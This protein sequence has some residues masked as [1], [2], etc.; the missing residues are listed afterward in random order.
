M[1]VDICGANDF[2]PVVVILA[3]GEGGGEGGDVP[4]FFGDVECSCEWKEDRD[5][6]DESHVDFDT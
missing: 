4:D 3:G 6:R 5:G 2:T 1:T